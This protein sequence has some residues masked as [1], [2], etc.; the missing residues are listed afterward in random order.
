MGICFTLL[1]C[2]GADGGCVALLAEFFHAFVDGVHEFGVFGTPLLARPVARIP[3]PVEVGAGEGVFDDG[4]F[5]VRKEFVQFGAE[6]EFHPETVEGF[7]GRAERLPLFGS[8]AF[9]GA[10]RVIDEYVRIGFELRRDVADVGLSGGIRLSADEYD[11]DIV[12]EGGQKAR[13]GEQEM[14]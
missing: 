3:L 14:K 9:V 12:G 13:G 2:H 7:G 6:G 5:P 11:V 8:L 1:P 10:F 4:D